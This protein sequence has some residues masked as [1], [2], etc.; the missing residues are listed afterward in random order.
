MK[1]TNEQTNQLLD[2]LVQCS[3]ED[4]NF[5]ENRLLDLID[6]KG[7]ELYEDYIEEEV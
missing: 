6:L 7:E 5:L 3:Y 4:V 1:L 2:L